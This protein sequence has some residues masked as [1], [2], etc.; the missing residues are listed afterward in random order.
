MSFLGS[1]LGSV[2]STVAGGLIG[3][4][5]QD[6]ANKQSAKMARE[7]MAFEERMSNTAMRRRVVDLKA[8]GL[9]PMLAGI[10]QQGAS[11]PAGAKSTYENSN[12]PL[13]EGVSGI[14]P[15]IMQVENLQANTAKQAAEAEQS[16]TQ[17]TLNE[18][19]ARNLDAT[20]PTHAVS[21][22]LSRMQMSEIQT[23]IKHMESQIG[24]NTNQSQLI[25][26]EIP[27]I[28]AE[29]N[30][31]QAETKNA[32]VQYNMILAT[33]KEALA[34]ANL[35]SAQIDEVAPRIMEMYASAARSNAET[36]SI[37]AQQPVKELQGAAARGTTSAADTLGKAA[38]AI[39][40]W[41]EPDS[42]RRTNRGFK[43]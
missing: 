42:S 34:R 7:Q 33:T 29:I 15:K 39:R 16:K 11:T 38:G 5:G 35:T 8:A 30:K 25:Q 31:I 13:S 40:M 17:A 28:G 20:T 3:K 19:S 4:S 22:D 2:A 36:D 6:D 27:K 14:M 24:L 26:A 18:A 41:F 37:R 32:G 12:L 10:N 23:K 1:V 21:M 9:N 43:P